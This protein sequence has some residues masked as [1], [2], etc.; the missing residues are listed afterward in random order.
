MTN[1]ISKLLI[2]SVAVIGLSA[3]STGSWLNSGMNKT[4]SGISKITNGFSAKEYH[5]VETAGYKANNATM[6]SGAAKSEKRIII[7][8]PE[9][10]KTVVQT[11]DE[12]QERPTLVVKQGEMPANI[13]QPELKAMISNN[14]AT[15]EDKSKFAIVRFDR[16]NVDYQQPISM[17]VKKIHEVKRDAEFLILSYMPGALESSDNSAAS[18]E[19]V[20]NMNNIEAVLIKSGVAANLISKQAIMGTKEMTNNEVHVFVK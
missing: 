4:S 12:T 14:V 2:T 15:T 16:E 8:K 7:K 18:I 1:K 20:S 3:C 9:A 10:G 11:M 19:A 5:N 13:E 17:G 6:K